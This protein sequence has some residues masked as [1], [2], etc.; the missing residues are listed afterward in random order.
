MFR[1]RLSVALVLGAALV[2]ITACSNSP[3]TGSATSAA[4]TSTA[5][6]MPAPDKLVSTIKSA[7]TSA[8]AVHIKGSFTDNGTAESLDVQLNKDGSASGTIAQGG[9]T[10]PIIVAKKVYYVQFT[11]QL[12]SGN[13][14]DPTSAAGKLLLNKWVPSTAT[15]L[16]GSGMVDGLKQAVDFNSLV[17]SLFDQ[18]TNDK[19]KDAGTDTVNGT[20]V[21]VYTSTDGSKA[22]IASTTPHYLMRLSEPASQGKGQLDFTGWNKPVKIS[23]P[24]AAD[25]YSG[26]GA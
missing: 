16:K 15:M 11:K 7:A 26:P 18:M 6:A 5:A 25:I 1:R 10:I 17:P 9:T 23:P 4:T 22:D 24:A 12:M 2:A 19:P 3:S 13:G 20:P 21:H 14:I 8:N